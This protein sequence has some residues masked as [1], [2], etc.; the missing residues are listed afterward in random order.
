MLRDW[1]L[2]CKLLKV[3]GKRI[4]SLP[5]T[6]YWRPTLGLALALTTPYLATD[7]QI[8]RDANNHTPL[9][10]V[11]VVPESVP[12]RVQPPML[13]AMQE[14]H[15]KASI[16]PVGTPLASQEAQFG[17]DKT[18]DGGEKQ[19]TAASGASRNRARLSRSYGNGYAYS[20]SNLFA[21]T[22]YIGAKGGS[23]TAKSAGNFA[24]SG[25]NG[26]QGLFGGTG[27]TGYSGGY[28]T[29]RVSDAAPAIAEHGGK[30]GAPY[31]NPMRGLSFPEPGDAIPVRLGGAR[32][33]PLS[34][35]G[36][37]SNEI[38]KDAVKDTQKLVADAAEPA[39]AS[40]KKAPEPKEKASPQSK[41]EASSNGGIVV[42]SGG[43][44]NV[45]SG[46]ALGIPITLEGGTL[47]GTG[48]IL[49]DLTIGGGSTLSPGNSPG[50][51]S[52]TT[53]TWGTDGHY[54]FEIRDFLGAAGI[55]WDLLNLSGSLTITAT[56]GNPFVIDLFSLDGAN[57][58]GFAAHFNPLLAYELLIA[59]ASSLAGFD[60]ALFLVDASGFL[61]PLGGG[62]W[63][64]VGTGNQILL[65]F[66]PGSV[67]EPASWALMGLGLGLLARR[68]QQSA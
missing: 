46:E 62:Q 53:E 22:G 16:K 20:D 38:G 1:L 31:E 44:L 43:I 19:A 68:R 45:A 34:E 51:L 30:S 54:H 65:R 6:I 14:D 9:P 24:S 42:S 67:P 58:P 11:A 5:Q 66:T 3:V 59:Q 13:L 23:F 26:G 37:V 56:A 40:P 15:E 41:K 18:A 8:A 10:Q 49:S 57:A 63:S 60:A 2:N 36:P 64:V 47:S 29:A 7:I 55:D 33:P 50:T 21:H 52:G 32:V 12:V 61:N 35:S 4:G 48:S 39:P 25:G 28:P 17:G 27:L